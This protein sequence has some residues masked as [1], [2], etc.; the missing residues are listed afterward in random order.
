MLLLK[1]YFIVTTLSANEERKKKTL[2]IS[3]TN[4]IHQRILNKLN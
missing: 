4:I 1:I 3:I 2:S